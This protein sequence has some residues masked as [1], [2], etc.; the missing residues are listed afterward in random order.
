MNK[1][2]EYVRHNRVVY[3]DDKYRDILGK[4]YGKL[5]A[6][7]AYH[8]KEGRAS[9][10]IIVCRCACGKISHQRIESLRDGKAISCGCKK[11]IFRNK[12]E[13][14]KKLY[15]VLRSMIVRCYYKKFPAYKHYG[16]RGIKVC[17]CW[18]KSPK[19]FIEWSLS[20]GYKIGLHID[21]ID[22][23]RGY[24]PSNCRYVT[25]AQNNRNKRDNVVIEFRGERHV[26]TDWAKIVGIPLSCLLDRKR[27]GWSVED[28]L[29]TPMNNN[30]RRPKKGK[31]LT[32]KGETH[33][34]IEWSRITG[35]K[36]WTLQNRVKLGWST[37]RIFETKER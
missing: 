32:Y 36:W 35:L 37:E 21:R 13:K 3:E 16:G 22:N 15:S 6:K 11:G 20:H 31:T 1:Y 9:R 26:I 34:L 29:T 24:S 27:L 4:K 30:L 23:N 25:S 7:H 14:R 17:K 2:E 10:L 28:M 5:T 19:A 8:K 33:S 12:D 18:L